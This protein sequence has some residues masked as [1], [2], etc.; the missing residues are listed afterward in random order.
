M[1]CGL[2][3][4]RAVSGEESDGDATLDLVRQALGFLAEDAPATAAPDETA[5][6]LAHTLN[7]T[8]GELGRDDF[9]LALVLPDEE[10]PIGQRAGALADWVHGFLFGYGFGGD[11]GGASGRADPLTR[12]YGRAVDPEARELLADFTEL[13]RV[14]VE[15]EEGD[16]AERDLLELV[17][18]VR[19]G[20][21]VLYESGG[22]DAAE[23]ASTGGSGIH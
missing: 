11:H 22:P 8:A 14:D 3:C 19:V 18:F 1:V 17:E 2:L 20:T 4:G 12:E 16:D 10:A 9:R 23:P 15:V 5:R 21:M 13:A 7:W 6:L